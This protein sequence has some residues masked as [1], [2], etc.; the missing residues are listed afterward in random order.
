LENFKEHLETLKNEPK[1]QKKYAFP[2]TDQLLTVQ[3][4]IDCLDQLLRNRVLRDV[5]LRNNTPI[6]DSEFGRTLKT[7]L[8]KYSC[9][10]SKKPVVEEA[11]AKT[12]GDINVFIKY[13]YEVL[14]PTLKTRR[15]PSLDSIRGFFTSSKSIVNGARVAAQIE[16]LIKAYPD[17]LNSANTVSPMTVTL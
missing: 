10:L 15:N 8:E 1:L 7:T 2:I 5:D 4:A 6:I 11:I 16:E 12:D 3:S 9:P 13:F 17:Q 14:K